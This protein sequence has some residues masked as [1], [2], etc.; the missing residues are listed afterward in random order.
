MV[1]RLDGRNFTRLTKESHDFEKPFDERFRDLMIDTTKH[2]MECGFR[3]RYAYT[4]SD[5]IS[6]LLHRDE[7]V[8]NRK[9]RVYNSI[10]AGEA[11]A[12]FTLLLN[13]LASFDCR[14]VQLP[15]Q[16]SVV[17]YFRWRQETAHY[18]ALNG[19]CYWLLREEGNS[20]QGANDILHGMSEAEKNEILSARG[21]VYSNVPAWQKKGVGLHWHDYEVV[22]KNPVTDKDE[23]SSRRE[24]VANMSLPR[25]AVYDQFILKHLGEA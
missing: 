4:Q 21:V 15:T 24:I 19:H 20:A 5:E 18:N 9:T 13:D 1:A 16:E 25:G 11:S 6:L 2:L 12:K 7:D 17:D 22:G 8:F 23:V 14:I 3:V 10:L